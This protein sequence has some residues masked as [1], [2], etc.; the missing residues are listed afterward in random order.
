MEISSYR[1]Y[2]KMAGKESG[3]YWVQTPKYVPPCNELENPMPLFWT[4]FDSQST[5]RRFHATWPCSTGRPRV[6]QR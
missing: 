2:K 1:N 5:R 4:A 3:T 6:S